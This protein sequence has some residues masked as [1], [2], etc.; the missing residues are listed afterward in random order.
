MKDISKETINEKDIKMEEAR[1]IF[2]YKLENTNV[3]STYESLINIEKDKTKK[4][5]KDNNGAQV[6][7]VSYDRIVTSEEE[8]LNDVANNK[9]ARIE[10]ILLEGERRGYWQEHEL[11]MR[12][13]QVFVDRAICDK[14]MTMM[15]DTGANISLMNS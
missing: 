6:F 13:E 7:N 3:A 9:D 11:E 8:I 12:Y 2:A 10:C 4:N 1:C 14:R 15:L 5:E